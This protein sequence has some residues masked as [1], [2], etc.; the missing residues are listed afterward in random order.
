LLFFA[1]CSDGGV[2]PAFVI[3]RGWKRGP[4]FIPYLARAAHLKDYV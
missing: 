4:P 1:K 2:A 3:A